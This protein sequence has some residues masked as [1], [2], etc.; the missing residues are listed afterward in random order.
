LFYFIIKKFRFI[1]YS[2]TNDGYAA[3]ALEDPSLGD[4][5]TE[6]LRVHESMRDKPHFG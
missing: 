5:M 3:D 6:H 1:L 4:I 2:S